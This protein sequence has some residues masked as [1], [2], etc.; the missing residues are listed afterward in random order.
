MKQCD[1]C[2]HSAE[3]GSI[4]HHCRAAIKRARDQT[5][6][7]FQGLP[8]LALA[9][10]DPDKARVGRAAK[11]RPPRAVRHPRKT[12]EQDPPTRGSGL[13]EVPAATRSAPFVWVILTLMVIAVTY[14][15]YRVIA[16]ASESA[17]S[18]AVAGSGEAPAASTPAREGA[19]ALAAAVLPAMPTVEASAPVRSNGTPSNASSEL[20]PQPNSEAPHV[21][22]AHPAL[23][24]QRVAARAKEVPQRPIEAVTPTR[25]VQNVATPDSS[26][27]PQMNPTRVAVAAVA[28]APA[29]ARED[30]RSDHWQRMAAAIR[31]CNGREFLGGLLCEQKVRIEYC[32]G[33]WGRAAE[34]P[35]GLANDHGQ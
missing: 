27:V 8:A 28:P 23:R 13:L 4:C 21:G 24:E 7:Q 11:V 35:N 19:P 30:S 31:S 33:W 5:V 17:S 10:G 16:T 9:G 18:E 12:A 2:G 15:A 25:A 29:R 3:R 6:S 22:Q 20:V 26:P 32:E 34:C 14:V 1:I